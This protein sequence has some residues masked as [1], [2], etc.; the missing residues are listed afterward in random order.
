MASVPTS[1]DAA[2]VVL[3]AESA[4]LRINATSGQVKPDWQHIAMHVIE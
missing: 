3:P 4:I 1:G 2:A